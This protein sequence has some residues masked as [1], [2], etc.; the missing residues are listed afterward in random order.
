MQL[1]CACDLSD[2]LFIIWTFYLN[3]IGSMTSF[4]FWVHHETSS[5]NDNNPCSE[6]SHHGSFD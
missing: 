4:A 6:V 2:T 1:D 5:A 3:S